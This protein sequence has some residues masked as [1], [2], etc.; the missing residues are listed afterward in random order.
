MQAIVALGVS[1]AIDDFG[2]GHSSFAYLRDL[3][4]STL[5]LDR[6]FMDPICRSDR[7]AR[8][9]QGMISLGH[10][11]G[12]SIVGEGVEGRKQAL[13]LKAYGCDQV[14]GFHFAKPMTDAAFKDYCAATARAQRA[15]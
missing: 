7:D 2:T 11:L 1:F 3:P 8:V 12:L 13:F 4:V 10:A 15:A 5:K 14:Q 9:C 6:T